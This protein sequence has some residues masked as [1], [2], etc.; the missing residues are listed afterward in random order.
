MKKV[1]ITGKGSYIG[2]AVRDWLLK[3]PERYSVDEVDTIGDDWKNSDFSQYDCIYHVA[4]IAHRKDVPDSLYENV[5]HILAVEVAKKALEEGVK[6]FIFMSSGAVYSQ[7]DKKHRKIKVNEGTELTPCTAYGISK[8]RAE[9]DLK[10]LIATSTMKLVILR[11]PMVYGKGAK[12]NYN[13]L[14]K[15]ASNMPIFPKIE[16]QRS[17]IY[18][19]NLCE[20]IRLVIDKEAEGVYLP[21]NAEYVVTYQ[22]VREIAKTSGKKIM[23]T[24]LFNWAILFMAFFIDSV[25]KAFGS[26]IYE[27]NN[28]FNNRYQIVDFQKSVRR[29][30]GVKDE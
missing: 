28:Y 22:L 23:V 25:N 18:I 12:G 20:F 14:A 4:G 17:M 7:N 29:T 24:S 27:K 26:Y 15:I 2:N 6:Q 10:Q 9:N 8:M 1:L 16:N 11:P 30:E 13:I 3:K 5:N 19:D 21:Q